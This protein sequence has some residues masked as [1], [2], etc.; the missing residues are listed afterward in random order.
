MVTHIHNPAPV[1]TS[2][3]MAHCPYCRRKEAQLMR[4][5]G[6]YD[7][8][9]TCLCCGAVCNGEY[10]SLISKQYGAR[11]AWEAIREAMY[12][13]LL[14]MGGRAFYAQADAGNLIDRI[15]G[16]EVVP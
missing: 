13:G 4:C 1:R 7:P 2:I 15:D 5:Y 3:I 11:K 10:Y 16:A 12:A 9:Y 14:A 6:W 8:N